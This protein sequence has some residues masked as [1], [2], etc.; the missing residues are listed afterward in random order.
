[1]KGGR[2]LRTFTAAERELFRDL[3]VTRGWGIKAISVQM[4]ISAP[5]LL[6]LRAEVGLTPKTAG[7]KRNVRQFNTLERSGILR[8]L[9]DGVSFHRIAEREHV[10]VY[11]L[12]RLVADWERG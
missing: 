11:R 3:Y 7:E 12:R 5:T 2:P 6:R 8:E 10:F 9:A 1:M 4:G